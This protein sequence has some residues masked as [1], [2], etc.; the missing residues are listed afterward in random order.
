MKKEDKSDSSLKRLSLDYHKEAP[1][2]KIEINSSKKLETD[3]DLSLAYSP[4]VAFACT[5]IHQNPEAVYDYTT[6]GN[7]VAV[8]SNGTAVLGLGNIGPLAAKPVME[9]KAVLFKHFAGINAID[10][11]LNTKNIDEFVATC[12][13][14]EP[15]IGGIN[16][17][18]I[19][20]PDCFEIEKRLEAK[21]SI[22]VF[23]DDQHGTAIITAASL[24]NA[25]VINKKE[26]SKIK[27]VFSGA[28][29]AAIACAN[30]IQ[31]IGVL[32]EN[33]ILCD[34]RGVIYKDRKENM[35]P[36]KE[37]F[38][39][40]TKGR[41]LADVI[42]DADVFIGLS[43]KNVL[44][45]DMARSMA[46]Y[47]IIFA[48]AN[49]DPEI[50]P[51][52]AKAACKNVIVATGR[53]DFANQVN[54][55]LGFPS[56]FRAALDVKATTVNKEMKMAAAY[57][58]A[59]LA[60]EDVP[61]SVFMAYGG[62]RFHFGRNYI[63]P[64]PFDHRVVMRVAPAVAKAAMDSGVARSPIKD[65]DE[66]SRGLQAIHGPKRVFF[67]QI[68]Q[69]IE[70]NS[71]KIKK[72]RLIFPEGSGTRILKSVNASVRKE[73]YTPILVGDS[74]SIKKKI[75]EL[76][77]DNL[78][79]IEIWNP[80]GHKD[81]SKYVETYV[82]M[83]KDVSKKE[84][85]GFLTDANAF[86]SMSVHLGDADGLVTGTS[87]HY[88]DCVKPIL[89]IIGC[90]S[91]DLA[92]GVNVVL[93]KDKIFLFA[94]S[95]VNIDPTA[96]QITKI[97]AQ[98]IKVAELLGIVPRIALLSYTNFTAKK[99]GPKK[100]KEAVELLKKQYPNLVIDGEMQADTAVNPNI[101]KHIFPFSEMKQGANILIFPS[102]DAGNI[103]YKLIQQLGSGDVIGPLLMGVNKPVDIV[104]RTG[105]ADD[106]I[107][108]IYLTLL[109]IQNQW[110][111]KD[112]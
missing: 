58:L 86:A 44:S 74:S 108:I 62:E 47:P 39:V 106:V 64:K 54:N 89:K 60:R 59:E 52:D 84:A 4:G 10:L 2:G 61:E 6:R 41:T 37:A 49:P 90:D 30:L 99:P 103:A 97:T 22:P 7:L 34:S 92:A 107:N 38:A 19:S 26:L 56:I 16:L 101:V 105:T 31:H 35:N 83:K 8:I 66:Y 91:I 11:E 81:F 21:L 51:D 24:I 1:A 17:E 109:R 70:S 67:S 69:R 43:Q 112:L 111:K 100:M 9:G 40:N 68:I 85:E 29:S 53:S 55:V 33:I 27:V 82:K 5:E 42:K 95:S 110:S 77:L 48:L 12:T 96:E 18:D 80:K 14:L 75:K 94:D 36:Y 28:G 88:A 93:I 25:C 73:L 65:F 71:K 76:E 98:A 45:K 23:H 72:P 104:Q 63:L 57:A 102:L 32:K 87:N 50:H 20:A 3:T 78:D 79:G 13:A 15:S 46:S